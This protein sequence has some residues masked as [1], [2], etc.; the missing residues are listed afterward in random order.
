MIQLSSEQEPID[1]IVDFDDAVRH[2]QNAIIV[3]RRITIQ[4][5]L[6]ALVE[7]LHRGRVLYEVV[8]QH[9]VEG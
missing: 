3:H 6:P 5:V 9:W 8:S 4:G 7:L 2:L 1:A